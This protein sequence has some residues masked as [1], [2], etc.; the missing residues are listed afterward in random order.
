MDLK[1]HCEVWVAAARLHERGQAPFSRAALLQEIAKLFGDTRPGVSAYVSSDSNAS[2]KKAIPTVYNYLVRIDRGMYRLCRDSDTVH[3]SRRG[4]PLFPDQGDVDDEFRPLWRKWS[5]WQRGST[6]LAAAESAVAV[7]R[8]APDVQ[9]TAL[10]VQRSEPAAQRPVP[11]APRPQPASVPAEA[12]RL[13]THLKT[14]PDFKLERSPASGGDHMG[15]VLSEV[16]LQAGV[17]YR[18]VVLPRVERIKQEHPKAKTTSAFSDLLS[19]RGPEQLLEFRGDKIRRLLALV[20]FLKKE[21]VETVEGLAA[22]LRDASRLET[23]R[24]VPGMG[25]KSIDYL[26]I[27]VGLDST[28]IDRH[29]TRALEEAGVEAGDYAHQKAVIVQA[30]ALLGVDRAVL[31]YSLWLY[32][33]TRAGDSR[34]PGDQNAAGDQ[35]GVADLRGAGHQTILERILDAIN[36]LDVPICDDCLAERLGL[37]YRQQAF[38][39]NRQLA[40]AGLIGRGR[41][42]CG[43]CGGRKNVNWRIEPRGRASYGPTPEVG[44]SG[45]DSRAAAPTAALARP[46][47]VGSSHRQWSWEGNVQ[48]VLVRYLEQ[49]GYRITHTADTASREAGKDIIALTPEGRELWVSVKGF[50]EPKPSATTQARHWFAHAIFDMVLYRDQNSE[51]SLAIGLPGGFKSYAALA[52]KVE[53]FLKDMPVT[54]YWVHEDGTVKVQ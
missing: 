8:M 51:A 13:V 3:E 46:D 18:N 45:P 19:A 36:T 50:P 10:G 40:S 29:L 33:S 17:N 28:A 26:Q 38:L 5:Q 25:P 12:A 42:V 11:A 34:R 49:D 41:G 47:E 6:D 30:A 54:L 22:W 16:I 53:W 35:R 52:K 1:I 37:K 39:R 43:F 20:N 27:L 2:A 21:G 44:L 15:A 9:R 24:R 31:D 14:L 4:R 7:Q 32:M 48:A 23:L